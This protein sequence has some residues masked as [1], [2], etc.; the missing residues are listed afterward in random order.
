MR[1]SKARPPSL[2]GRPS[3]SSS[4]DAAIYESD[5][6]RRVPAVRRWIL[7]SHR[8]PRGTDAENVLVCAGSDHSAFG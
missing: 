7:S 4:R 5:R 1:T 3:V 2:T 6:I 8:R